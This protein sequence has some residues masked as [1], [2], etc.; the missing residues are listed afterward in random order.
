MVTIEA[1]MAQITSGQLDGN[2]PEAA[3][4]QVCF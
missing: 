1:P 2:Q 3:G 4:Q